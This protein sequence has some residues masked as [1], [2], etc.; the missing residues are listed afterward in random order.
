L[1]LDHREMSQATTSGHTHAGH[2][3]S[4]ADRK[5]AAAMAQLSKLYFATVGEADSARMLLGGVCYCCKTAL[6]TGRDGVVY[7]AWRHVYPGNLRDMAFMMSRDG[8]RTFQRSVRVSEDQWQL[9]GCPD[10]GPAMAVDSRNGIHLV[11]PTL[12]TDAA[13]GKPSIGIFYTYST[14]GR[15]FRPRQQ[16]ATE[17]LA[18][19]PQI[20]LSGETVVV[21][22]DELQNSVRR[23]VIGRRPLAAA[24]DAPFAR[25]VLSRGEGAIY[26][27]LAHTPRGT[28]VAWSTTT[29]GQ[30]AVRVAALGR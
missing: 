20:A 8:G 6:V 17:G 22:W 7:A 18:H 25:A 4:P 12:V 23:I 26:P 9:D 15:T 28:L 14:D 24:A 5:D 19:H 29:E 30:S 2:D 11:W 1:W 10:D 16:L 13:S 27:A 3:A 21:A